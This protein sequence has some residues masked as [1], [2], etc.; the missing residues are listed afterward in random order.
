MPYEQLPE[1]DR[2]MLHRITEV[3]TEVTQAFERFQFFRFFQTVQ[4]F[5]VVDLSNFYL[6]VA[7]DRL[8]ISS[9][10]AFRRRSLS[11]RNGDRTGKLGKSDRTRVVPHGRRYLAISPLQDTL[12][13]GV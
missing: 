2:Y 4:N 6:D 1:L 3:F 9:P 12:Q 8:Y 11:N 13:I 10:D 5:C 7:K